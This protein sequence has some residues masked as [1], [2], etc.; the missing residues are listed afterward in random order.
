[1]GIRLG[2]MVSCMRSGVSRE[3]RESDRSKVEYG[4]LNEKKARKDKK[5]MLTHS[6]LVPLIAVNTVIIIYELILG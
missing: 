5:T 2:C 6:F 4:S 3:I 1:M